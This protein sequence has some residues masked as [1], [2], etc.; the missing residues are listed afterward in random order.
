[1][2][3]VVEFSLMSLYI[4]SEV[5]REFDLSERWLFW[6]TFLVFLNCGL[7]LNIKRTK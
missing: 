1:M 3:I 2:H 7:H 5:L 6:V 4:L